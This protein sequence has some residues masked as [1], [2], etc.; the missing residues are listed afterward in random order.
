MKKGNLV[1]TNLEEIKNV[2]NY[3]EKLNGKLSQF[4]EF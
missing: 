4:K 3:G 1:A 2:L